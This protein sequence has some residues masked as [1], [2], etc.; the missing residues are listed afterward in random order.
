MNC[1]PK[2]HHKFFCDYAE[3][4]EREQCLHRI[5][6]LAWLG[7]TKCYDSPENN[8]GQNRGRNCAQLNGA[9]AYFNYGWAGTSINE[10]KKEFFWGEP[11]AMVTGGEHFFKSTRND[12][13]SNRHHKGKIVVYSATLYYWAL[14]L[15]VIA[16]L[17]IPIPF[18]VAFHV[19]LKAHPASRWGKKRWR[20]DCCM[21]CVMGGK[22]EYHDWKQKRKA[23]KEEVDAVWR[24]M[25]GGDLEDVSDPGRRMLVRSNTSLG[26][27]GGTS[28][29]VKKINKDL[30]DGRHEGAPPASFQQGRARAAGPA[31]WGAGRG[32]GGPDR[33]DVV[34]PPM[35]ARRFEGRHS[36]TPREDESKNGK[37]FQ[38]GH[39]FL[40]AWGRLVNEPT[41]HSAGPG[42]TKAVGVAEHDSDFE[43]QARDLMKK[44]KH[45][46]D[47]DMTLLCPCCERLCGACSGRMS[48]TNKCGVCVVWSLDKCIFFRVD[49]GRSTS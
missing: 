38:R 3:S 34:G 24:K 9:S 12:D 1:Q 28:A 32:R 18:C 43:N 46:D 22:E 19:Y 4:D 36:A 47:E 33:L 39:S 15:T 6:T 48:T 2:E 26:R 5:K 17:L 20:S 25:H 35:R 21:V 31:G 45:K 16:L 37:A 30:F 13:F 10:N 27:D 7:Q 8:N 23:R 14:C 11:I 49:C 41:P 29:G 42:P 40:N 44:A